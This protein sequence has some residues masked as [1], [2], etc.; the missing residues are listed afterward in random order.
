MVL[1]GVP[2]RSSEPLPAR[3]EK[4]NQLGPVGVPPRWFATHWDPGPF[5]ES[6]SI[7][8]PPTGDRLLGSASTRTRAVRDP[9]LESRFAF[10]NEVTSNWHKFGHEVKVLGI[11]TVNK[12]ILVFQRPENNG[13]LDRTYFLL[14]GVAV[15]GVGVWSLAVPS[16]APGATD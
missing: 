2:P 7:D 5:I 1:C 4:K 3:A 15:R 6:L 12:I 16:R 14:Q 10:R 13:L 8:A 9:H 11:E